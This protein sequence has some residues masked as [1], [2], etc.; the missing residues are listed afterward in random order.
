[1][2]IAMEEHGGPSLIQ[3]L[4]DAWEAAKAPGKAYNEGMTQDEMGRAGVDFA[5]TFT[6]AGMAVPKPLGVMGMSGGRGFAKPAIIQSPKIEVA[7]LGDDQLIMKDIRGENIIKY[8]MN[9]YYMPHHNDRSKIT[10]FSNVAM[11]FGTR[12]GMDYGDPIGWNAGLARLNGVKDSLYTMLPKLNPSSLSY[13]AGAS[14]LKP[15]YN[16]MTDRIA[17]DFGGRANKD[18]A[19]GTYDI[20]FPNRPPEGSDPALNELLHKFFRPKGGF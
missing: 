6:G 3:L 14:N 1:M 11:S 19:W 12:G 17:K 7:K 5:R 15:L 13:T 8:L 9:R 20:Q 4:K 10:D 18:E 2:P 16:R